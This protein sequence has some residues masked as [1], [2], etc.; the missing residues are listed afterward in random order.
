MIILIGVL[1]GLLC[2]QDA[3][4]PTTAEGGFKRHFRQRL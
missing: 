4:D 3:P 2:G 1:A